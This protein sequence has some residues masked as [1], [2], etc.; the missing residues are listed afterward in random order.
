[1]MTRKIGYGI[2]NEIEELGVGSMEHDYMH[3][4]GH[5]TGHGTSK[6]LKVVVKS[7]LVLFGIVKIVKGN[8]ISIGLVY[9]HIHSILLIHDH[10]NI[11]EHYS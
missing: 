3:I 5:K 11:T 1:M 8:F 10:I 7:Q 6:N 9:F 4:K 2:V